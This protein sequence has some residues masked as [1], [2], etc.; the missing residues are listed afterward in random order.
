ME[1]NKN[2]LQYSRFSMHPEVQPHSAEAI[3]KDFGGDVSMLKREFDRRPIVASTC[4]GISH[5]AV[6]GRKF[7]YCIF[8]EAG[9]ALLLATLGPLFYCGKFVLVGDPQQL[10][11]VV[12]SGEARKLGLEKSLFAHLENDENVIPLTLQYRMNWKIQ[13]VANFLTYAGQVSDVV[14]LLFTLLMAKGQNKL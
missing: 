13:S 3:T 9:Q 10:P 14:K 6:A 12:Q 11:P 4:L 2:A 5:P 8:D 1:R 7:D